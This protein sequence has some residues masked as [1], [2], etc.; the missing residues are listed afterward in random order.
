MSKLANGKGA[1]FELIVHVFIPCS[2][3]FDPLDLSMQNE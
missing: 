2:L 1:T 3:F